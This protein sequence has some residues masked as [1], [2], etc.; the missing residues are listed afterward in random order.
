MAGDRI[1]RRR[2]IS[3]QRGDWADLAPDAGRA[4][5]AP[6]VTVTAT[7]GRTPGEPV[8]A[9]AQLSRSRGEHAGG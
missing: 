1:G 4:W 9:R 2:A 8:G 5:L 3:V 7:S 6:P